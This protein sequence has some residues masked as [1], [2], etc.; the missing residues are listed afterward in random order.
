M[1]WFP[2]KK[3]LPLFLL[4]YGAL[5]GTVI[6]GGCLMMTMP[7]KSHK[8]QLPPLTK[9]NQALSQRLKGDISALAETI[10]ERNTVKHRQL[11]QSA[12]YITGR[13]RALGYTV[14][15]EPFIADN[16]TVMNIE[17]ELKGSRTPNEIV[18]VGAHYDS[19]PD[20]PGANDNASGVAALLEL[21]RH[22]KDAKPERTL[23]FVAFVNEEPPFFQTNRMG[24]RVYAAG[25][26]KRG[27]NII[28]MLALETVGYYSDAANS[29]QYPP[30]FSFFFPDTGNFIGFVGNFNSRSLVRSSI[31]TFRETT[32]FP[33]EGLAAPEFIKGIGWSD[34]WAFWQEG[35]P[36]IMLTDTAPFRYPYYHEAEDTPDKLDYDRMARVVAGIRRVVGDLVR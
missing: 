1:K 25:A 36:G 8:G 12:E 21:A 33:S 14:R 9:E 30:P 22:F 6:L 24:S 29:Q 11:Q 10:G 2:N 26:R 20:S 3:E 7:G 18:V 4:R 19:P 28:A 13:F 17:A 23:R 27:E 34:H 5:I 31:K 35:Y 16:K 32:P 15:E